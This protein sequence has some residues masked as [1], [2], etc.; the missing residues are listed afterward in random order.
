MAELATIRA[1]SMAQTTQPS[2][3]HRMWKARWP[4]LFVAPFYISFSIF[5]LFPIVFSIY[6]SLT[7]WN[8]LA[9][10]KFVGLNNFSLLLKDQ[11]FWQS[12][13]NGI[14][15][16]VMY[17]PIMVFLALVL[18]VILNSKRIRAYRVFRA[19]I[20]VPYITNMVA[21]GFTFQLMLNQRQGLFNTLLG[22]I[23]V[24]PIPWLEDT[25]WAK[26]S[27][28]LLILWAYLGYHMVIMLAGLQTIPGELTEAAQIDGAD[29]AQAFFYI[30][31]PLMRP[32]IV[33]SVV[34]STMGSF[35]LFTEVNS[36]FGGTSGPINTALTPIIHI[37]HQAF[38]SNRLGYASATAYVYFAFVFVL[39]LFQVR[40]VGRQQT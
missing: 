7:E 26:V 16:F 31:V 6:L 18:A 21:A 3:W 24:A 34:L 25:F 19:L 39:T 2:L 8:G 35:D 5:A 17:V 4:Y 38:G 14:T 28:C 36:L 1:Q 27:L 15:L 10:I 37:F 33:F 11:L 13:L 20:F 30:T 32:T 9:P 29:R 23:G 12:L 40:Y 22:A